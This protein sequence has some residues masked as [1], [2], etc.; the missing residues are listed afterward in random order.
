MNLRW[1]SHS[2][3]WS[4]FASLTSIV[5]MI[6]WLMGWASLMT[7]NSLV[8]T[9]S[10]IACWTIT[11]FVFFILIMNI[12]SICS[13]RLFH[14]T[15]SQFFQICNAWFQSFNAMFL[16]CISVVYRRILMY[17]HGL[18]L[19]WISTSGLPMVSITTFHFF[20]VCLYFLQCMNNFK[21]KIL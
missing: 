12:L 20:R 18:T 7:L 11:A 17:I 15:C 10:M 14:F 6:R 1:L 21:F 4:D 5:M 19:R 2:F 16:T 9:W 13:W 8:P 3:C